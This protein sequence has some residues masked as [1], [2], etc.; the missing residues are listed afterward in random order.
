M[1]VE[2]VHCLND[3]VLEASF[4]LVHGDV[5]LLD[6]FLLLLDVSEDDV[7]FLEEVDFVELDVFAFFRVFEISIKLLP[8]LLDFRVV[9]EFMH[10]VHEHIVASLLVEDV[11]DSCLYFLEVETLFKFALQHPHILFLRCFTFIELLD[12]LQ[13]FLLGLLETLDGAEDHVAEGGLDIP[14]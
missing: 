12:L 1:L 9:E 3:N 13:V 14:N 10:R 8:F 11:P 2:I 6:G 5:L 4:S 7:L